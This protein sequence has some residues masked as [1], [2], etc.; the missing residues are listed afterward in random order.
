MVPSV[1]GGALSE[2]PQTPSP[3]LSMLDHLISCLGLQR[4]RTAR[5]WPA[6]NIR[7]HVLHNMSMIMSFTGSCAHNALRADYDS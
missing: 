2:G 3:M 6:H 5:S 1:Y 7:A 4:K